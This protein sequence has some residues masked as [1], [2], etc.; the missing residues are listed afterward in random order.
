M[1]ATVGR[2]SI[3]SSQFRAF[4]EFRWLRNFS[5]AAVTGVLSGVVAEC[6]NL[7]VGFRK[8]VPQMEHSRGRQSQ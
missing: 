2:Q 8:G 5:S 3:E 6:S 1:V 7:S 4:V